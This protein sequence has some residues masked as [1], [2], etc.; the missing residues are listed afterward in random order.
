[1]HKDI[2]RMNLYESIHALRQNN[3]KSIMELFKADTNSPSEVKLADKEGEDHSGNSES[4]VGFLDEIMQTSFSRIE[5]PLRFQSLDDHDKSIMELFGNDVVLQ[6]TRSGFEDDASL[7]T[8]ES[9]HSSSSDLSAILEAVFPTSNSKKKKKRKKAKEKRMKKLHQSL[10]SLDLSPGLSPRPSR[11]RKK[12]K[13]KQG[14]S[15]PVLPMS[16]PMASFY[17]SVSSLDTGDLVSTDS[18][19]ADFNVFL[20]HEPP[21]FDWETNTLLTY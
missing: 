21:D 8:I 20:N 15:V 3:N 19:D 7:L 14:A 9:T 6:K 10:S 16:G 11:R 12:K 5:S 13:E 17:S 1:M 2:S 4:S 18:D